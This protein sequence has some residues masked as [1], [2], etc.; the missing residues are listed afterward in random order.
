MKNLESIHIEKS[1]KYIRKIPDGKGGWKYIY[2]EPEGRNK[3]QG[4]FGEIFEGYS[5]KPKEAFNKLFKEKRGQCQNVCEIN[6][7]VFYDDGEGIKMVRDSKTNKPV[8][9]KASIDF[10]WGDKVRN[11]G[12][13]HIIDDHFIKHNDFNSIEELRD[14]VVEELAKVDFSNKENKEAAPNQTKNKSIGVKIITPSGHKF[15]FAIQRDKDKSGK[16]LLRHYILTSYDSNRSESEKSN[17]SKEVIRRQ[18]IFDSYGKE[19]PK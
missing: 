7:P 4:G 16:L 5:G 2:E 14:K 17:S 3:K 6:L 11:I 18:Q 8:L 13:D 12:L 10:V 19:K 15:V 9:S 1:F